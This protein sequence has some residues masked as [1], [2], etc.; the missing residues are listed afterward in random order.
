MLGSLRKTSRC[1]IRLFGFSLNQ[2]LGIC[3]DLIFM[4]MQVLVG[5]IAVS[6]AYSGLLHRKW[7]YFL[8]IYSSRM[9]CHVYTKQMPENTVSWSANKNCYELVFRVKFRSVI[10]SVFRI[11]GLCFATKV[12]MVCRTLLSERHRVHRWRGCFCTNFSEPSDAYW[13]VS[14][15]AAALVALIVARDGVL[16]V[17]SFVYRAYTLRWK[18]IPL[19]RARE[20]R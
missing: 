6:M 13:W 7:T 8:C 5:C 20:V 19:D 3:A 18:V 2:K 10:P 11:L 1:E 17:G 16:L 14:S 9:I 4:S 15:V 12:D